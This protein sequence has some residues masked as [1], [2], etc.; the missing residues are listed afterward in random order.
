MTNPCKLCIIKVNCS[1]LCMKKINQVADKIVRRK[2]I[3]KFKLHKERWCTSVRFYRGDD[4]R[5]KKIILVR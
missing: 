3:D 4:K 2:K 1:V 5:R